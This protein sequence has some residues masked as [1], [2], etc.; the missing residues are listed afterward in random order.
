MILAAAK[1]YNIDLPE[2]YMTGDSIKDALA[3][4]R[5]GCRPALI[6]EAPQSKTEIIEGRVVPVFSSL[7]EFAARM[8]GCI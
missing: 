1:K 4:L 3:G 6:R 8:A 2:S 5:A 7:Y